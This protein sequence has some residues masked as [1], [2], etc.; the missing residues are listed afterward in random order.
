MSADVIL[1]LNAGSSS[2]KFALFDTTREP[3]PREPLWGGKVDGITTPGATFSESGTPEQ[4]LALPLDRP[5]HAALEH[6]RARV[7]A[8]LGTLLR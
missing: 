2:I 5:Y 8:Q 3:L 1:V 4:P 6:I 7:T